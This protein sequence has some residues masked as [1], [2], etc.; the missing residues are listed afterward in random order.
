[1]E[2]IAP[3]KKLNDGSP[4]LKSWRRFLTHSN[5]EKEQIFSGRVTL[6]VTFDLNKT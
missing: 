4:Y 6:N 5:I 3:L 2:M 1:M